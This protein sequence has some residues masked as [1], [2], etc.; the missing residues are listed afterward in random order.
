MST[1]Q[2]KEQEDE[3]RDRSNEQNNS[4]VY[5][6]PTLDELIEAMKKEN[7]RLLHDLKE[8]KSKEKIYKFGLEI[9]SGTV[10]ALVSDHLGNSKK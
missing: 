3:I 4:V 1:H 7:E 5:G 6:P 10:E 9:F 8:S 2:N